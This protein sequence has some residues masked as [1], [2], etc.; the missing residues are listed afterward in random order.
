MCLNFVDWLP[1]PVS[2]VLQDEAEIKLSAGLY[3][4]EKF[5]TWAW[6]HQ[7]HVVSKPAFVC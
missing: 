6:P 7:R 2:G 4:E 1:L 5:L 3:L